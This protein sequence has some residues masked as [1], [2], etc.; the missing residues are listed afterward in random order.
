MSMERNPFSA[1]NHT[2]DLTEYIFRLQSRH[3]QLCEVYEV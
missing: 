2:P 3:H 1:Q